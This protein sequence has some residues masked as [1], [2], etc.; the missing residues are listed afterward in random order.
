MPK[1]QKD[2]FSCGLW[3]TEVLFQIVIQ[4]RNLN[5][6]SV[7]ITETLQECRVF[8]TRLM[9][10]RYLYIDGVF[11][12]PNLNEE[13]KVPP[14]KREQKYCEKFDDTKSDISALTTK[15]TRGKHVNKHCFLCNFRL[16]PGKN[17]AR[18]RD[19]FHK[20]VE[21][22][23]IKCDPNCSH[24]NGKHFQILLGGKAPQ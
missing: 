13:E 24:C 16:I 14:S 15:T 9:S 17:W 11:R 5:Q 22:Q 8:L 10:T 20:D 12:D 4:K 19:T 18:H 3:A 6:I 1:S 23:G 21:V 2:Y 7:N